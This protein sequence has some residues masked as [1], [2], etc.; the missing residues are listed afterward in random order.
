M[1]GRGDYKYAMQM[2]AEEA[3][4][5][6]FGRDYFDLPESVRDRLYNKASQDYVD[7]MAQA[8]DLANDREREDAS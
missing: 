7:D 3:A 8:A 5:T 6:E 1:F 2:R 4:E